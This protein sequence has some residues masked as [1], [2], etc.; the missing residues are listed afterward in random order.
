MVGQPPRL[1]RLGWRPAIRILAAKLRRERWHTRA[2]RRVEQEDWLPVL[3]RPHMRDAHRRIDLPETNDG[4]FNRR[5]T[6]AAPDEVGMQRCGA[7]SVAERRT[8]GRECLSGHLPSKHAPERAFLA[9]AG[10]TG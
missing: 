7:P 8:G 1:L 9:P 3:R 4:V 10:V 6:S 5:G 2:Q